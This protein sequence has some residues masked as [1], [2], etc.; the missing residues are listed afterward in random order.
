MSWPSR[1][2]RSVARTMSSCNGVPTIWAI[3]PIRTAGCSV[4]TSCNGDRAA[5]AVSTAEPMGCAIETSCNAVPT[6]R[7]LRQYP[8]WRDRHAW[9]RATFT[10]PWK[11]S[12]GSRA[13]RASV[14]GWRLCWP[15]CR[16]GPSSNAGDGGYAG[17]DEITSDSTCIYGGLHRP[18][19]PLLRGRIISQ[20][21]ACPVWVFRMSRHVASPSRGVQS[22]VPAWAAIANSIRW[23]S[24]KFRPGLTPYAVSLL[25][26]AVTPCAICRACPCSSAAPAR[27][28]GS[29]QG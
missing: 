13:R 10:G 20:R 11:Y 21:D 8:G 3:K 1:S 12:L 14:L 7:P 28:P 24:S 4:K 26:P 18:S 19:R 9:T 22:T 6:R 5:L 15:L 27:H 29:A 25:T 23:L 16:R 17:R 2:K